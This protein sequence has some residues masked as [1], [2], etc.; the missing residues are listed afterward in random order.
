MINNV[1]GGKLSSGAFRADPI[2]VCN[3]LRAGKRKVNFCD[4]FGTAGFVKIPVGWGHNGNAESVMA[5]EDGYITY[6]ISDSSDLTV[7]YAVVFCG[8]H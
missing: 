3:L 1:V 5:E 7:L 4:L 2:K 8:D 6:E